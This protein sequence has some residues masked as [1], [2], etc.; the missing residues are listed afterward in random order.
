MYVSPDRTM[1]S[2]GMWNETNWRKAEKRKEN[3]RNAL[4]VSSLHRVST[5]W[6]GS[7][8]WDRSG[9]PEEGTCSPSTGHAM[10]PFELPFFQPRPGLGE[11]LLLH[12]HHST[13]GWCSS[14]SNRKPFLCLYFSHT[15]QASY[16]GEGGYCEGTVTWLQ[17]I[18][19][20]SL[21][22]RRKHGGL[23]INGFS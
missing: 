21:F 13:L 18:L 5:N 19:Q 23:E 1:K 22:L 20:L 7:L 12:V 9:I 2:K 6:S 8:R 17:A 10:G 16:T 3:K 11:S 14:V 15:G 4:V